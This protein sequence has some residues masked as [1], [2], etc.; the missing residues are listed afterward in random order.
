MEEILPSSKYTSFPFEPRVVSIIILFVT[1]T[2]VATSAVD[3][4]VEVPGLC[5]VVGTVMCAP[6]TTHRDRGRDSRVKGSLRART[7]REKE[8]SRPLLLHHQPSQRPR[9]NLQAPP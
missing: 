5:T 2:S 3:A 6:A 9:L 4:V 7:A 1:A 8:K